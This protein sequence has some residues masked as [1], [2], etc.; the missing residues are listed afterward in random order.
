MDGDAFALVLEGVRFAATGCLFVV[1]ARATG[2][3]FGRHE[4]TA[5]VRSCDCRWGGSGSGGGSG[6]DAGSLE[7]L[8]GRGRRLE[9]C[10]L[11]AAFAA[12]KGLDT[13]RCFRR[14]PAL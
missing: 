14:F 8:F 2:P 10:R 13:L 7:V 12:G 11:C 5:V 1:A 3:A 4:G 9:H 6:V